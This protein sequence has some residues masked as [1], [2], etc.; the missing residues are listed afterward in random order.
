[1][2]QAR[3]TIDATNLSRSLL[4]AL[5]QE[6]DLGTQAL[7][8]GN[9][10]VAVTFF[11]S[12]LQK[13]SAE[14]PFYDH[15]VHN[16]LLGY[17]DLIKRLIGEGKEDMAL[18]FVGSALSPELRGGV[19]EEGAGFRRRVAEVFQALTVIL[20]RYAKFDLIVECGRKAMRVHRFPSDS[21]NLTN[22]LTAAGQ[23]PRLSD[24][25]TD[26]TP[27]QLGRHIF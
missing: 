2:V 9:P 18:K 15:L 24:F 7:K 10:D 23:P 21:I 19:G 13:M 20:F 8:N 5:Q 6:V 26:I 17:R 1:M 3:Q 27:E 22:S 25:T 14:M 16:L 12:A 4:T 11:Q